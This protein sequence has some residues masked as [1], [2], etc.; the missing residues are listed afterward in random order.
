LARAI[1]S[2]SPRRA[3]VERASVRAT[4]KKS[5]SPITSRA[6]RSLA[7]IDSGETISLVRM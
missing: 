6:A 1:A 3:D 7:T 2:S 4:R 5:A